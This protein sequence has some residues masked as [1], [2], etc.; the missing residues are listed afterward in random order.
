MKTIAKEYKCICPK[1]RH[2]HKKILKLFEYRQNH[3][4]R[5]FCENCRNEVNKNYEDEYSIRGL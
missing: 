3:I 4:P 2:E 5:I 1:C